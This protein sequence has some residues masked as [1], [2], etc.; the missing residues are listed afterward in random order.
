LVDKVNDD[1]VNR[2]RRAYNNKCKATKT[3]EVMRSDIIPIT[4]YTNFAEWRW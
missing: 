4:D 2:R 1:N 3:K